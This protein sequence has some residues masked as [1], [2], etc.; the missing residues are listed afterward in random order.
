MIELNRSEAESKVYNL[1]FF[2]AKVEKVEDYSAF[3]DVLLAKK[4]DV[5]RLKVNAND[6]QV[7]SF[8]DLL[9]IPYQLYNMLYTNYVGIA[10]LPEEAFQCPPNY[11]CEE[12]EPSQIER[13]RGM[14]TRT[15]NKKTWVNYNSDLVYNRIT[16]EVE[17][18]AS[19]EYGCSFYA[20]DGSK[21][22]WIIR[23]ENEDIGF[24]M[25]EESEDGF[26]G[27]FYGILPE[28]RNQEHSKVVYMLMLDICRKRGYRFFKNDIGVMN[29]PSQKS[30]ASQ[31]MTPTNIYF[32][33]ELYPMLSVESQ[34]LFNTDSLEE[35]ETQ[36]QKHFGS[37]LT[38][39]KISRVLLTEGLD[40]S[41]VAK[42]ENRLVADNDKTTMIV[43]KCLDDMGRLK[44]LK[45]TQWR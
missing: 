8:L 9:G 32:H 30:A 38:E 36:L 4:V 5:L 41:L 7:Y 16:D 45:Y 40:K 20:E 31:R 35:H 28:H 34:S 44:G 23:Y 13:M 29:I 24:F 15:I 6:K 11:T 14:V 2:R 21:A 26:N 12:F 43:T 27:T 19:Q 37:S 3:L 10:D 25:G 18:C 39:K 42:T 33:F 17:L 1:E 22:S